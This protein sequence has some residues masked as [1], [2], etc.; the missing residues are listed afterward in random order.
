MSKAGNHNEFAGITY[1]ITELASGP[2]LS[3][4]RDTEKAG[5]RIARAA[6]LAIGSVVEL[7]ADAEARLWYVDVQ[8]T[9]DTIEI[10]SGPLERQEATK[11][12][13]NAARTIGLTPHTA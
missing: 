10:Y 7:A 8:P 2:V 6:I 9:L 3:V 4:Y 1:R 13:D 11:T 12:L 5:F